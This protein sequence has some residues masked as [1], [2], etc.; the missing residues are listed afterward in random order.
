[1]ASSSPPQGP[2]KAPATVERRM[3][4][5]V[6]QQERQPQKPSPTQ[7]HSPA[8][9]HVQII[10]LW[11]PPRQQRLKRGQVDRRK[12]K[13]PEDPANRELA[14]FPWP[15][16][17]CPARRMSPS[18]PSLPMTTDYNEGWPFT[19]TGPAMPVCATPTPW[20]SHS[21]MTGSCSPMKFHRTGMPYCLPGRA[22]FSISNQLK[23]LKG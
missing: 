21:G 8:T 5:P 23:E 6:E 1:M 2:R 9:V 12:R 19:R 18:L 13:L 3:K 14:R 10:R 15:R 16:S 22:H 17:A 11:N 7:V 20:K 4:R